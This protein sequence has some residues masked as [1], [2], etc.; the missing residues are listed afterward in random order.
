[1][2]KYIHEFDIAAT[3]LVRRLGNVDVLM[4]FF[5][6][7]G[8]PAV[9][10]SIGGFILLSGFLKEN[11]KVLYVGLAVFATI[12][13][14]SVLKLF[15]HRERPLTEYVS[16]MLFS[17]FSF[18]SGHSL[19]T[20]IA[21][22]SAAYLLSKLLPSPWSI[23]VIIAAVLVIIGV[24]VS[25]IY[26]GAHHPSDVLAGWAVGAIGLC[27]VIFVIRPSF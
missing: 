5:S 21:Y 6:T 20:T 13:L 11:V 23:L 9:T 4:H 8:H 15:F 12:G 27:V 26:L 14:G 22:G 10:L 7:I 24:G 1:M 19:G 16:N 25:R 17:T 2:R 3:A 18:P